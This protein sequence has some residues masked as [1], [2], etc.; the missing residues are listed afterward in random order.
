MPPTSLLKR[1]NHYLFMF[2]FLVLSSLR[3]LMLLSILF[4]LLG[5]IKVSESE[6]CIKSRKHPRTSYSA[7]PL[8]F[9]PFVIMRSLSCYLSF[10]RILTVSRCIIIH[11]SNHHWSSISSFIHLH[12]SF[13]LIMVFTFSHTNFF[14]TL[15]HPCC[16]DTLYIVML[17][18]VFRT[19]F[20]FFS[21]PLK[22]LFK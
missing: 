16:N 22:Y 11:P 8:I 20:F 13:L 10:N 18:K 19:G 3:F 17:N 12:F 15:S 4:F 5:W 21:F 6:W 14:F 9:H 2:L 1:S 7:R